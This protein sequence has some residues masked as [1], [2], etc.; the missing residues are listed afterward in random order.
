VLVALDFDGAEITGF[1]DWAANARTPQGVQG[2]RIAFG[3]QAINGTT[4][5]HSYPE[6]S[7]T[8]TLARTF[9]NDLQT[10]VVKEGT[11]F[12]EVREDETVAELTPR[13]SVVLV[14][15]ASQEK[16]S[17]EVEAAMGEVTGSF[18]ETMGSTS[19]KLDGSVA[20]VDAAASA[21]QAQL[22]G[23]IEAVDGALAELS[24]A[25][26]ALT[27]ELSAAASAAQAEL[28]AALA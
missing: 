24:G 19:A 9:G 1:L 11:I 18:E 28:S 16:V 13:Y 3:Y 23:K 7:P 20:A 26:V 17:G 5:D 4:I 14:V 10:I 22:V 8:L 12:M 15:T 2:N 27:A 6:S 21:A 25:L